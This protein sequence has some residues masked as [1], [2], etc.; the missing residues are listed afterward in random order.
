[1]GDTFDV[2]IKTVKSIPQLATI[3]P[4]RSANSRTEEGAPIA[5]YFHSGGLTGGSRLGYFPYWLA[6]YCNDRGIHLA[7]LDYRLI[8]TGSLK[9]VED[10]CF[11]GYRYCA[12]ALSEELRERSFQPVDPTR[13]IMYAPANYVDAP[14]TFA[15]F[16]PGCPAAPRLVQVS[17]LPR[18]LLCGS[19]KK[20][21]IYHH[22][23]YSWVC[24]A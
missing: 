19:W 23:G 6:K 18:C 5:L 24:T 10:D 15:Y 20:Q 9:D 3:F 14:I 1:M 16:T 11:D 8:P 13:M 2:V 12:T 4:A 22:L 21:Q 7:T 17:L